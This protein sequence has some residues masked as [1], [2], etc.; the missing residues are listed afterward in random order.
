MSDSIL[1]CEI[2]GADFLEDEEPYNAEGQY[3]CH[4]CRTEESK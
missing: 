4:D 2:C 3:A 1:Q